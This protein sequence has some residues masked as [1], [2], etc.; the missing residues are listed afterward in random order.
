MIEVG[1]VVP[2]LTEAHRDGT[3]WADVDCALWTPVPDFFGGGWLVTSWLPFAI[4]SQHIH[5]DAGGRVYGPYVAVAP[6]PQ[7]DR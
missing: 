1:T 6:G 5:P 2:E 3:V 4:T 7:E